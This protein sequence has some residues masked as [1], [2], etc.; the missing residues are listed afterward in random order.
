MKEIFEQLDKIEEGFGHF[1]D[2][3]NPVHMSLVK[4]HEV[5]SD[6]AQEL[7]DLKRARAPVPQRQGA[8]DPDQGAAG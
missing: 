5:C 7:A 8:G 2:E 6:L 4:M 3:M 1:V